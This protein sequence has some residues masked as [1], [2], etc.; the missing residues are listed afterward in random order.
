MLVIDYIIDNVDR[1][2]FNWGF[3]VNTDTGDLVGLHPLLDHN[4]ALTFVHPQA[5]SVTYTG[6]TLQQ[7]ARRAYR[8][9]E[10]TSFVQKILDYVNRRGTKKVFYKLFGSDT[11]WTNVKRRCEELLSLT[12][13]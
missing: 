1:H 13:W 3:Q 7:V 4:C 5:L 11:Q 8:R 6:V 10:D 2:S 9:L 12:K